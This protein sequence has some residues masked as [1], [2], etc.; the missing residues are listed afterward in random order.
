M[1]YFVTVFVTAII[2]FL[3]ATIYYKGLPGFVSPKSV[4]VVLPEE[5]PSVEPEATP[6]NTPV[7]NES[8]ALIIKSALVK[9]HGSSSA[10]LKVSVSKIEGD[11][12]KGTANDSGG[13]GVWFAAKEDGFWTLAWDGNGVITCDDI[14][15]F[16]GFP[17]DLIPECWDSTTNKLI[18]R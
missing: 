15:P 1:K 3:G 12:A 2:V 17:S 14:S 4:S 8:L 7:S 18:T 16:P 5:S 11:Y 9:E 13:G 6:Q 10:N